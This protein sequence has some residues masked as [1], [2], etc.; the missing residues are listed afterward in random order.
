MINLHAGGRVK[1]TARSAEK[2]EKIKLG[3]FRHRFV[4][5]SWQESWQ[6]R[7][8]SKSELSCVVHIVW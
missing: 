7:G 1:L 3:V 6:D 2:K 5:E 4:Q 8:C